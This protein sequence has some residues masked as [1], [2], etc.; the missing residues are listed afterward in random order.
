MIT[1]N[2]SFHCQRAAPSTL[3]LPRCQFKTLKP[4]NQ[5]TVAKRNLEDAA[6]RMLAFY[7]HNTHWLTAINHNHLRISRIIRSLSLILGPDQAKKF[8]EEIMHLV[9]SAGHPVS[10]Q[11]LDHWRK[12]AKTAPSVPELLAGRAALPPG[13]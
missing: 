1:S 7:Q 11:A 8:H 2:G 10:S 12:A 13:L 5:S 4:S 9:E 6:L 3:M